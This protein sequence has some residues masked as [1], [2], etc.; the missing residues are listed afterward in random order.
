MGWTKCLCLSNYFGPTKV[1]WQTQ[2]F[3]PLRLSSS[4]NLNKIKKAE[5]LNA[6]VS[7]F[8]KNVKM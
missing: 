6:V 5:F 8:S 4:S 7:H 2:T 1:V 3:G